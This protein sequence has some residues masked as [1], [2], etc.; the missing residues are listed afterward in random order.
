M[1]QIF[2]IL[3]SLID[4]SQVTVEKIGSGNYYCQSINEIL[5]AFRIEVADMTSS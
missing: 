5:C 2:S 4:E 3:Q 1:L